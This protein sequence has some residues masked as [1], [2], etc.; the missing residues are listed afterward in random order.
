MASVD[1][2]TEKVLYRLSLDPRAREL[3]VQVLERLRRLVGDP[4]GQRRSSLPDFQWTPPV[5]V[6]G[7][8][9]DAGRISVSIPAFSSTTLLPQILLPPLGPALSRPS[10]TKAESRG[11][12]RTTARRCLVVLGTGANGYKTVEKFLPESA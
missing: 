12:E 6:S 3:A 5:L 8:R 9:Q 11:V 10:P 1:E 4:P 2:I 7:S